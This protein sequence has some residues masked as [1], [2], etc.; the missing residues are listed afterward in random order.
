M[1]LPDLIGLAGVVLILIAY[2]AL[3]TERIASEDWRFSAINGLGAILIMISLYFTFNLASF[4]IE[5]FWLI[6]SVYGL[7]KVWRRRGKAPLQE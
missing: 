4:V 7:W 6:I 5:V 2:F 3:Q 1:T